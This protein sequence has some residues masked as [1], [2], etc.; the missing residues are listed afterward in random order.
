V[1]AA[2]IWLLQRSDALPVGV[3]F[4]RIRGQVEKFDARLRPDRPRL[5]ERHVDR[6]LTVDVRR[7]GGVDRELHS[8][9]RAEVLQRPSAPSSSAV[10]SG[11]FTSSASKIST[12]CSIGERAP[13]SVAG[14]DTCATGERVFLNAPMQEP[15]STLPGDRKA[16]ILA[17][18]VQLGRFG[19]ST[20][21]RSRF[22][23]GRGQFQY[24]LER[25]I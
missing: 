1:G 25:E 6:R 15:P 17:A 7:I 3:P 13:G 14:A 12:T 11:T 18:V 2:P 8:L 20:Y 19:V 9:A 24:L 22:E 5:V 23:T 4:R 16:A 10:G 21:K